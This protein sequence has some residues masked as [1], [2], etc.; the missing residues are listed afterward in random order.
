[1]IID[2]QKHVTI[3][4]DV[5]DDSEKDSSRSFTLVCVTFV[6]PTKCDIHPFEQGTLHNQQAHIT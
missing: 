3:Y 1:M 2:L 6:Q 5:D 4:R